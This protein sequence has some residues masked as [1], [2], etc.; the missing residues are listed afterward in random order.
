MV[1]D[2]ELVKKIKSGDV[3]AFEVLMKKYHRQVCKF[4]YTIVQDNEAVKDISQETFISIYNSIYRFKEEGRFTTW[5]FQIAKNKSIDYLRKN[6]RNNMEGENELSSRESHEESIDKIL[7]FKE[8]KKSVEGFIGG[9]SL[10]NRKLL[11][12]KYYHPELTFKDIGDILE[13][14]E[15]ATK[16]RYYD[17]HKR[18]IRYEEERKGGD[19]YEM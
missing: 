12:L 10:I 7:E 8:R 14:K 6:K 16:N 13:L 1:E 17:L 15:Q 9:L 2:F 19:I 18:Y 4:V 3:Q 11:Y 5:L